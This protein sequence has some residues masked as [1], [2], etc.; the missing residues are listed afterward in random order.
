MIG[1]TVVGIAVTKGCTRLVV[2]SNVHQ[3]DRCIVYA[4]PGHKFALGDRVWWQGRWIYWSRKG[5]FNDVR[6]GKIG[7][8]ASV[9]T[10]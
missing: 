9:E 10:A 2:K 1:G 6:V 8:S 3:G 7:N 5:K 4:D